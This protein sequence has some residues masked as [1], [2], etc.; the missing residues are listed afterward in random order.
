MKQFTIAAGAASTLA[1]ITATPTFAQDNVQILSN[2]TYDSLY[3]EGWSVE[4]M[5]GM[6]EVIDA[7]GEDIGDIENIIFSNDGQVLGIIAQVGG[8]WDIGD[9]HVH[10]PWGEVTMVD[11]IQQMQVPVTEATVDD[12]DVFGDYWEED[13]VITEAA[14]DSSQVVDDDLVAG[15]GIFKATDLIG[16]YAY[17]SDDVRYGY[18]S[19]IIIE[20]GAISAIVTD[21]GAYGRRGYYANPYSYRGVSPMGSPRYDMPYDAAQ[22]DT[23]EAFDYEQLQSRVAE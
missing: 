2:W 17:L 1:I 15:P 3:A 5:F 14:T 4:N 16:S 7:N 12:Y 23:I 20:D 6:T 22:V 8:F 13:Q 18:I 10:V 9:T 11:G 19:D 21:A